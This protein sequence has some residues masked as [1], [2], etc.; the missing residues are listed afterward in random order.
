MKGGWDYVIFIAYHYCGDDDW[1][2][3]F[4]F[5]KLNSGWWILLLQPDVTLSQCC[6]S[7]VVKSL[8]SLQSCDVCWEKTQAC[9]AGSPP[10]LWI[11]IKGPFGC[12]IVES[13]FQLLVRQSCLV[14]PILICENGT[15]PRWNP[16]SCRSLVHFVWKVSVFWRV[17]ISPNACPLYKLHMPEMTYY[18]GVSASVVH[19]K[20]DLVVHARKKLSD[21]RG[22][23]WLWWWWWWRWWWWWY[24]S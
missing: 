6:S 3:S 12:E 7:A 21:T 2:V 1:F 22:C 5:G 14:N 9:S 15:F 4:L 16:Y 13:Q 11:S 20:P 8:P 17:K 24:W 23:W 19:A 10:G 18:R